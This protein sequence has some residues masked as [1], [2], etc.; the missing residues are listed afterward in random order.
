M[1]P[2]MSA[3]LSIWSGLYTPGQLSTASSTPSR[4]ASIAMAGAAA[5]SNRAASVIARLFI[6]DVA[7]MSPPFRVQLA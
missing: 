7:F 6:R 1:S 4:S 2:I 3:S 5:S